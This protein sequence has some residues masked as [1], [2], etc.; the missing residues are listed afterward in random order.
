MMMVAVVVRLRLVNCLD[1]LIHHSCAVL[2]SFICNR[3]HVIDVVPCICLLV[4]VL[5][6]QYL[7][8]RFQRPRV[9]FSLVK[10]E[11]R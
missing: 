4:M 5:P 1:G 6:L 9:V 11:L 3:M 7:V 8:F 2:K 10:L